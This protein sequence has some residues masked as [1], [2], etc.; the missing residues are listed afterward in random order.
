[1]RAA[2]LQ[3]PTCA[4]KWRALQFG[5]PRRDRYELYVWNV[6]TCCMNHIDLIQLIT[7]NT[8]DARATCHRARVSP[9]GR[10]DSC[11]LSARSAPRRRLPQ[12]LDEYAHGGR[13]RLVAV[14]HTRPNLASRFKMA[15]GAIT[16]NTLSS[17]SSELWAA[18]PRHYVA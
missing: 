6:L 9:G 5:D 2:N 16:C 1:M 13:E 10:E 8:P 11:P 18:D 15:L 3:L 4:E 7:S 17:A 14:A 12:K